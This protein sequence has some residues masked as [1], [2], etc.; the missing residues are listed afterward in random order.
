MSDEEP[1]A[2]ELAEA[3]ALALALDELAPARD[4]ATLAVGEAALEPPRDALEIATLLRLAQ[5]SAALSPNQSEAILKDVLRTAPQ[6]GA[7]ERRRP[8]ILRRTAQWTSIFAAAAAVVIAYVQF[9]SNLPQKL[10]R[11][12]APAALARPAAPAAAP[13]PATPPASPEDVQ[14]SVP[15]GELSAADSSKR[16]RSEREEVG[17]LAE[18]KGRIAS[19]KQKKGVRASAA[20]QPAERAAETSSY[21]DDSIPAAAAPARRA[22]PDSDGANLPAARRSAPATGL[23]KEAAAGIEELDGPAVH[24]PVAA[25][26]A[27]ATLRASSGSATAPRLPVALTAALMQTALTPRT[28]L[29]P[30]QRALSAYRK[31]TWQVASAAS[32]RTRAAY[33]Q[34]VAADA[35]VDR[36]LHASDYTL[37][38]QTLAFAL[39]RALPGLDGAP[40]E[41]AER[42]LLARLSEVALQQGDNP[43]ALQYAQRGL[44]VSERADAFRVQLLLLRAHAFEAQGTAGAAQTSYTE[45]SRVAAGISSK[46]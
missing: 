6:T 11:Q 4:R 5:P 21:A 39:Q 18:A 3:E 22:K 16:A 27:P 12:E 17:T 8:A 7:S 20:S 25:P 19:R 32:E 40:R 34:L 14:A 35:R 46:R 36:A 44:N 33:A 24:A 23:S 30:L 26:S 15:K 31:Q 37:A 1:T 45:A 10:A 42:A 13:K 9:R 38:Q 41:L 2:R 28:S 29:E 43:R